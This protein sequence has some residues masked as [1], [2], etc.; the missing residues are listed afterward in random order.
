MGDTESA[1]TLSSSHDS[2]SYT[3]DARAIRFR[4]ELRSNKVN[5]TNVGKL[6]YEGIPDK[7]GL[8]PLI[9]KVCMG[10]PAAGSPMQHHGAYQQV[11]VTTIAPVHSADGTSSVILQC[12]HCSFC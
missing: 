4:Q 7:Y 1:L 12:E 10:S 2:P 5:L 3:V 9:W 11:D 8:R 6:A